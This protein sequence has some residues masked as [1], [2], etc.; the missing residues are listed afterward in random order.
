MDIVKIDEKQAEKKL[1]IV[2]RYIFEL[3]I[4]GLALFSGYLFKGQKELESQ[5]RNYLVNDRQIMIERLEINTQAINQ[6]S[7]VIEEMYQQRYYLPKQKVNR[8]SK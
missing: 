2:R 5:I 4:V 7:S 8:I 6:N 3:L 1:S